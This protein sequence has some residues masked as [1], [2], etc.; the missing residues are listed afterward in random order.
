MQIDKLNWIA[1]SSRSSFARLVRQV[2][3][4]SCLPQVIF[5]PL[6]CVKGVI[7]CL[8]VSSM[9]RWQRAGEEKAVACVSAPRQTSCSVLT[10]SAVMTPE[11]KP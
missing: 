7:S 8:A 3:L 6:L 11:T 5:C 1:K 2:E 9:Y 10:D 4:K